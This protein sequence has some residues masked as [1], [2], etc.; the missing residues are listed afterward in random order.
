MNQLLVMTCL[1]RSQFYFPSQRA[2]S[3]GG[4]SV[5]GGLLRTPGGRLA[6]VSWRIVTCR[7]SP[8]LVS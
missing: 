7:V 2:G 4:Q 8:V 3:L 6:Q 5:A 1:A